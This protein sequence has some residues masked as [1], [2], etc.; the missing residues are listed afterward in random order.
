VGERT[1]AAVR[2]NAAWCQRV[3][4]AHGVPARRRGDRWLVHGRAPAGYPD[5]ITLR[6]GLTVEAALDGVDAG[7]G[8]SVKDSWSDLDLAAHGFD[9]LASGTWLWSEPG[10]PAHSPWTTIDASGLAAWGVIHG[11]P[12]EPFPPA[13]LVDPAVHLVVRDDGSACAAV[14]SAVPGVA[15]VSNLVAADPERAW[16][17]L[18]AW[19]ADQLPGRAVVGWESGVTLDAARTAGMSAVGA[20]RVWRRGAL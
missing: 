10:E 13:L 16:A 12:G 19:C 3:C 18:R 20:L 15:G 14:C 11:D 5:L 2:D 4:A 7:P 6:P 8:C 17:E 1:R 9:V